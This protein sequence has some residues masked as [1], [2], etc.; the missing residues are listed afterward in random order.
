MADKVCSFCGTI[1]DAHHSAACEN[2]RREK[3]LCDKDELIKKM[4]DALQ[5]VIRVADCNTDEFDAAKAALN[6]ANA[7]LEYPGFSMATD[8]RQQM[9]VYVMD[10]L[11]KLNFKCFVGALRWAEFF[12]LYRSRTSKYEIPYP[13]DI[14]FYFATENGN[15][16]WFINETSYKD[17][18]CP[19][20]S[21]PEATR[22]ISEIPEYPKG[23][24]NG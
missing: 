1:N 20:I 15:V 10:K 12:K 19:E 3:M 23:R 9:M 17:C 18:P 11:K 8:P 4:A 24:C 22:L 2:A 21:Y 5:G 13:E 14:Y 16:D 6:E 7:L